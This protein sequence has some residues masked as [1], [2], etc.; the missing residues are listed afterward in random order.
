MKYAFLPYLIYFVVC[1]FY[2]YECMLIGSGRPASAFS[3][4]CPDDDQNCDM[5]EVME[6]YVRVIFF[7]LSLHQ[8]A[9]EIF[10]MQKDGFVPYI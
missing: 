8:L 4:F 7:V 2:Y 9:I 6:P 1:N 3:P 5:A 10:Q